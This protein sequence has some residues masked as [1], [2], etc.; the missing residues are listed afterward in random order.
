MIITETMKFEKSIGRSIENLLLQYPYISRVY[1]QD[2]TV[3]SKLPSPDGILLLAYSP[4]PQYSFPEERE[5]EVEKITIPVRTKLTGSEQDIML[6]T[7][8]IAAHVLDE[9][10]VLLARVDRYGNIFT[11]DF[12]H[13]GQPAPWFDALMGATKKFFATSVEDLPP[14][15]RLQ[16]LLRAGL[17][18]EKVKFIT[19]E[20]AFD[21][22]AWLS[23]AKSKLD[24]VVASEKLKAD[25]IK[26]GFADQIETLKAELAGASIGQFMNGW[27]AAAKFLPEG[28]YVEAGSTLAIDKTIKCTKIHKE[29]KVLSLPVES[30]E[31]F[32]TGI[33]L[34]LDNGLLVTEAEA[35]DANHPNVSDGR[36]ICLGDLLD[37]PIDFVLP[38]IVDILETINLDSTYENSAAEEAKEIWYNNEPAEAGCVFD[39]DPNA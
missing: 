9:D 17:P 19:V 13:E 6:P 37:K 7:P 36:G 12:Y 33:R 8:T 15:I 24:E 2:K 29:G 30:D 20:T 34:S 22:E 38:R 27:R 16:S 39:T 3:P 5:V 35:D 25:A 31:F 23:K 32:V 26:A 10:G 28:W 11:C 14:I 18:P 1:C 21:E 4:M